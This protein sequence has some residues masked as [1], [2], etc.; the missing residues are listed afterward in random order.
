MSCWSLYF[1]YYI[2]QLIATPDLKAKQ[3][4]RVYEGDSTTSVLQTYPT[5]N[6]MPELDIYPRY[7]FKIYL[8]FLRL[9]P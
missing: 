5:F 2:F 6:T 4:S 3:Y 9:E 1:V 7:R 8:D